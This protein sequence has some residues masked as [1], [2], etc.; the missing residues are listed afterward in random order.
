MKIALVPTIIE[1]SII[2]N[3]EKLHRFVIEASENSA[4][5]VIFSETVLTGL[6]NNDIPEHDF[7][8]TLSQNSVQIKQIKDL[9]LN[10]NIAIAFGY[11]ENCNNRIYDS[12]ICINSQGEIIANYRRISVGWHGSNADASIYQ[13]GNELSKFNV[14]N[15]SFTSLI[16]GDLFEEE[17]INK[18]RKLDIDYLLVP[19]ARAVNLNS[20]YDLWWK[21]EELPFYLKQC[22][23]ANKTTLLVNCISNDDNEYNY[24][25]GAYLVSREGKILQEQDIFK[26]GI[27]YFSI[28]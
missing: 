7:K 24:I 26:E 10:Y 17:L 22:K 20:N 18:V 9:A 21:N 16:C 14:L 5:F 2:Q 28:G 8:L 13:Q 27:L 1:K 12:F 6:I 15:N 25:G 19:F 11:L 23:K 4:N 3:I